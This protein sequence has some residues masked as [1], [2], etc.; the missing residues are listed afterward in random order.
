MYYIIIYIEDTQKRLKEGAREIIQPFYYF[1]LDFPSHAQADVLGLQ[2]GLQTIVS[3]LSA[4][5]AL[6]PPP[7]GRLQI[8]HVVHIN[9]DASRFQPFCDT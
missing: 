8:H 5:A 2:V 4:Q 7:K 6:L 9:P 3:Q 1:F